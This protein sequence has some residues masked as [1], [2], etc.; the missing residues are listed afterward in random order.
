MSQDRH[1][2]ISI[3]E[4]TDKVIESILKMRLG[5]VSK[6]EVVR[7]SVRKLYLELNKER[8]SRNPLTAQVEVPA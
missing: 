6:S 2:S 4:E 8:K 1:E 3:P 7:D 5:Y